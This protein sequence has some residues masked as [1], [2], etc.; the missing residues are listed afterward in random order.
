MCKINNSLIVITM[1]LPVVILYVSGYF[2]RKISCVL[3]KTATA[4]RQ[5]WLLSLQ[6]VSSIANFGL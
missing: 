4:I 2:V 6:A 1:L 3:H 5:W